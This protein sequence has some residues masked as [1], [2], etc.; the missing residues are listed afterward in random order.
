MINHERRR[1]EKITMV[2]LAVTFVLMPTAAIALTT[3]YVLRERG[4]NSRSLLFLFVTLALYMGLIN[5]TKTPASDQINY[6]HAYLLVPKQTLWESLTNIYGE[7][8]ALET[9][10]KEIG[11][12]MLNIVGYVTSFGSYTSFIVEFT[13]LLYLLYFFALDKFFKWIHLPHRGVYL[14]A[15]IFILCFFTQ[16]FNLTIHLQ[17][18]YIA[19]AVMIY[20]LV[21]ATINQ[22]PRWWLVAVGVLLHT[23][24][25][26]FLPLFFLFYIRKKLSFKILAMSILL[27]SSSI[28]LMPAIFGSLMKIMG[29]QIYA[30]ERL[31]SAGLS[32][33][34]RFS[35]VITLV[36]SAPNVFVAARE[37]YRGRIQIKQRLDLVSLAYL[38]CF[39]FSVLNPDNTMQY[40]Y[41]MMSYGFM[42]FLLPQLFRRMDVAVN[43]VFLIGVVVFFVIRFY[44]TFE[45]I[46]FDYAPMENI[47]LDN[48][49]SLFMYKP[50]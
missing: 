26:L 49:L 36:F 27:F 46:V 7:S 33:E 32:E 5:A 24:V 20:A 11:Y 40:R 15:A 17:R 22:K 3:V 28:A 19:S 47:L 4:G 50:L 9:S 6:M 14:V 23:S 45:D 35:I 37:L 31:T 44:A 41:F 34:T 21:D 10:A 38:F 8:Y 2:I 16:F 12:G 42:P 25:G 13:M 18:Q 48:V 30:L 43:K 1:Y 29:F 39:C